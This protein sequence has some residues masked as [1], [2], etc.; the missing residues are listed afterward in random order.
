MNCIIEGCDRRARTRGLCTKCYQ[1]A[2][3][4]VRTGK[5]TWPALVSSG[6]ALELSDRTSPFS[7]AFAKARPA[8][9]PGQTK[10]FEE[11]NNVPNT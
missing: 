1:G 8:D 6:L 3:Y 9:L 4:A 2:L 11:D 10:M 7:E 5:T